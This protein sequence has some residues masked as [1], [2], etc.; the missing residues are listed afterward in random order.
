MLLS[1]TYAAKDLEKAIKVLTPVK[2]N[3]PQKQLLLGKIYFKQKTMIEQ[4]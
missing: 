1:Q 4:K 2:D 3:V